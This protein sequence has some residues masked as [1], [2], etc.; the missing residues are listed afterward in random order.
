MALV[1]TTYSKTRKHALGSLLKYCL[2]GYTATLRAIP[3][4]NWIAA[5][6]ATAMHHFI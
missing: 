1:I 3:A 6:I 4:T 2:N 5:G